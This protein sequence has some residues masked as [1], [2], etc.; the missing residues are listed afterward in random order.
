M[1]F[2]LILAVTG[3]IATMT[4]IF[5]C[6]LGHPDFKDNHFSLTFVPALPAVPHP[7]NSQTDWLTL[8][9]LTFT[10]SLPLIIIMPLPYQTMSIF[11]YQF[12]TS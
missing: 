6:S 12:T 3:D 10:G 11:V 2:G 4:Q 8:N 1:L 5:N 7:L 9:I